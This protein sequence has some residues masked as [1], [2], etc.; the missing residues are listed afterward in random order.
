MNLS[1]F[2]AIYAFTRETDLTSREINQTDYLCEL[3]NKRG[4]ER[5]FVR[6]SETETFP[7]E[8]FTQHLSIVAL[9]PLEPQNCYEMVV[10]ACQDTHNDGEEA[11]LMFQIKDNLEDVIIEDNPDDIDVPTIFDNDTT[12]TKDRHTLDKATVGYLID[13]IKAHLV[14]MP[15]P[16]EIRYPAHASVVEYE[17]IWRRPMRQSM[18]MP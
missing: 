18:Q 6:L 8:E 16:P 10:V 17:R 4:P 14:T 15:P 2:Q 3:D 5:V 1:S 11:L 7:D 13:K 12:H 9:K